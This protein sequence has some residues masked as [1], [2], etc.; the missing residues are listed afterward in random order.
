MAIARDSS[1]NLFVSDASANVIRKVT[2]AGVVSLFAGTAGNAGSLDGTGSAARFN[3][4]GGLAFD[5]GGNLYIADTGNATIRKITVAGVV[6]TLAGNS[7]VRGNADATGS[8][9]TFNHPI[10]LAID[11]AG[12]IYVADTFTHTVRKITSGGTVTTL[13]GTNAVAGSSDGS[14]AA[15]RFSGPAG[16]AVDSSGTV[17]VADTGNNTLRKITASGVVTTLAGLPGVG[18]SNDGTGASAFFGQPTSLVV[19]AN[20][21]VYVA[22]T[23]NNL[24]RRVTSVGAVTLLAGVPGIAGLSDG[25]GLDA[26]LDQPHGMALDGN[27]A[28]YVADT[29]NAAL[30]KIAVNGTV[31]TAALVAAPPPTPDPVITTPT[32]PTTPSGGSTSTPAASG[33]GG[34][35]NPWL[36]GSLALLFAFRR[37]RRKNT[38]IRNEYKYQDLPARSPYSQS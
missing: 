2:A 33:G 37:L 8:A 16:L 5:A 20:G 31:T 6:T 7:A 21:T 28:L 19:D 14:G 23:G 17:Y 3:Q 34:A 24:I 15:A 25:V 35:I 13:A 18:G 1:G 30:R 9:A 27:G 26:L 36:A 10:G 32:T 29:G 11:S 4:P 12:N 38:R 22:D